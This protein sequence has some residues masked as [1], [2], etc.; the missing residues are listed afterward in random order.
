MQT[1]SNFLDGHPEPANASAS[2]W[3]ATVKRAKGLVEGWTEYKITYTVN[4]VPFIQD[5]KL[6]IRKKI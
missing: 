5:P 3:T 2:S 1:L 6:Q 4:G